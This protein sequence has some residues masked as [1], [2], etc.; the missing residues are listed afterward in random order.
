M[1]DAQRMSVFMQQYREHVHL[2]CG[3]TARLGYPFVGV[4]GGEPFFVLAGRGVDEPVVAGGV[5][6]QDDAV[7]VG[8]AEGST[9]QRT[10]GDRD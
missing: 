6:I 3:I 8:L 9:L 4:G 10:K 1:V 5:G 2:A 7:G